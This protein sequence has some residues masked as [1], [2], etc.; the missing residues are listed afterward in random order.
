MISFR[1][2]GVTKSNV[3][4]VLRVWVIVGNAALLYVDSCGVV[5]VVDMCAKRFTD[6]PLKCLKPVRFFLRKHLTT[7]RFEGL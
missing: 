3:E 7:D 2:D 6:T 5:S 4:D 1:I